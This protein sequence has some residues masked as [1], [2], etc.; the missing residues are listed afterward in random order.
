[1]LN[2]WPRAIAE[3]M[4]TA[5]KFM[6][7]NSPCFSWLNKE[8]LWPQR[9]IESVFPQITKYSYGVTYTFLS[10]YVGKMNPSEEIT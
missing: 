2:G 8:T 5:T 6:R 7:G 10:P 9:Y 3:T 1:M 4:A